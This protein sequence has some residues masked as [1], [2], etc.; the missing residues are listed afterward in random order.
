[1]IDF[2][3]LHVHSPY[4]FLGAGSSL[5]RLVQRAKELGFK[6]L[7]LTDMQSLAGAARFQEI[8]KEAGLK[9]VFGSEV[10]LFNGQHLLLLA[11]DNE[12]YQNLSQLLTEGHLTNQR[13][14]PKVAWETL[15]RYQRGIIA[16]S[17]CR[18]GEI[19]SL[20]LRG[21]YLKAKEAL[22]RYLDVFGRDFYLEAQGD[23]LPGQTRL[24]DG[25]KQLQKDFGVPLVATNN[26][27]Y[28]VK[29]DFPVFD[30]LTCMSERATLNDV[31]AVRRL[32]A[33][34]YLKAASAMQEI[35][36][37]MPDALVMSVQITEQCNVTLGQTSFFPQYPLPTQAARMEFLRELT[38]Q[39]AKERYG[40]ITENSRER[41]EH[42]L[43]I[44]T[45]LEFADYFLVVWDA[46]QFAKRKG[47]RFAGRGSA[48]DSA[49]AYCLKITEVDSI[50]RGLLF[51][52]FLSMERAEKP[53]I[54]VDFDARYR[55]QVAHYFKERY[56]QDKVASVGTYQTFRARSAIREVGKVLGFSE[57]EINDLAKRMPW[58]GA[59]DIGSALEFY[60]ELRT[61]PKAKRER[62][63]EL[64]GFC[65][66]IA[67]FP[68]FLGT[69]LGGIV[70]SN[71]P[72]A[73]VV[74]LQW[75]GKGEYVIQAN[76]RD[77]EELGLF[78]IDLLSLRTLSVV[79]DSIQEIRL[80]D[81]GFQEEEVTRDD[82][83]VYARLKTGETIGVFQLESPAQRA[84]QARLQA[85]RFEDI[86]A[87][88]ALIRP[89]PIKGDM[90]EP[91][92]A[93]RQGLKPIEYLHPDLEPILRKTYGVVLFQ[94]QA[95]EIV[96]KI[97]GFTLG[98]ADHL[99]KV[100]SHARSKE[101]MQKLGDLFEKQA[102]VRGVKWEVAQE[103]F[104]YLVG[105][106]SYG[107]CEAHAA[108]FATTSLK[109]AYLIEHYPAEF[110]TALFNHQPMGYYSPNTLALEA[111]R[112]GVPV[113]PLDVNKSPW[114][115]QTEEN[116]I[117]V[118][119]K[120]LKNINEADGKR[121]L[122]VRQE[123]TFSSWQDFSERCLPS[124][125]L[126]ENLVLAGGF[127]SLHPNRKALL[128]EIH[129]GRGQGLFLQENSLI[130]YPDFTLMEKTKWE[131]ESLHL[132]TTYRLME[133]WRKE[134][135]WQG[136]E[137]T[138]SILKL[139]AGSH[140]SIA[141][142]ILRPHRPPT[143]SGQVVVFFTLEDEF[144]LLDVTMFERDY[145]KYGEW[146]FGQRKG[147][148]LIS[149]VIQRRGEGISLVADSVLPVPVR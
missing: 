90:V 87:S 84:L 32:N 81:Q 74:P 44:I 146:I 9:A 54:D 147:P 106:A 134:N 61:L 48:A 97:A 132:N 71:E 109:T 118:G 30:I 34:N 50:G 51:E 47:I 1:M 72:I 101:E 142:L 7:A 130:N 18:Q 68:K 112:R 55:D 25:L 145:Q 125:L 123:R 137:T 111:K 6:A 93:R 56:G 59:D 5:W 95:I 8:M 102:A 80:K 46:L 63:R 60:P 76:K 66:R 42:E 133:L 36:R 107:F 35:F 131:Y 115:F 31:L 139:P 129:Q 15:Q 144:G 85:D 21:E 16:L 33:E 148:R 120:Q 69:H 3:H 143:R 114:D 62:Y 11:K 38:W 91:Y 4:S 89:G 10:V 108:A 88:V 78:K 49:V 128:W 127:T 23:L 117:R 103:I 22:V 113:L 135:D 58:L 92:I 12:G 70:V 83:A 98:E 24:W 28:A 116:S 73:K 39:G 105:Y 99:R 94:E 26:V 13:G 121:I 119:L 27:H 53:D 122:Q 86:V 52:R 77:I 75:S 45:K 100:M 37:N 20:L 14:N 67:E 64:F 2:V 141:G 138:E 57:E 136:Y 140:I 65:A 43:E 79:E 19:P 41:L 82:P 40:S 110:F 17:G 149:G 29:E 96:Q 104:S 124:K 126:L